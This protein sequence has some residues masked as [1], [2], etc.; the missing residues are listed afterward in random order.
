LSAE[1]NWNQ[2]PVPWGPKAITGTLA[3]PLHDDSN[4]EVCRL[5]LKMGIDL[6]AVADEAMGI[7]PNTR[8]GAEVVLGRSAEPWPY[9]ILRDG[10]MNRSLVSVFEST[11]DVHEYVRACGFDLFLHHVDGQNGLD[12]NSNSKPCAVA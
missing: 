1:A 3:V 12:W 9:F 5:L 2:V 4:R 7:Q 6:L 8:S 11:P 10:R